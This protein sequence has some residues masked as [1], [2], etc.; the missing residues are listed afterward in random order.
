MK[1]G[2]WYPCQILHQFVYLA[3]YWILRYEFLSNERVQGE[4]SVH[5]N[6]LVPVF[7]DHH[8]SVHRQSGPLLF[9]GQI[10]T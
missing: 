2:E 10:Q 6:L 9:A 5:L 7:Y 3:N 1:S 4:V 8:D